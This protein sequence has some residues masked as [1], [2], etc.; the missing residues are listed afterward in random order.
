MIVLQ[1]TPK[2]LPPAALDPTQLGWLLIE[3]GSA[4]EFRIIAVTMLWTVAQK[5]PVVSGAFLL[6]TIVSR[7][8]S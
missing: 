3:L 7:A 1:G 6:L 5:S 4:K 2:A 8:I